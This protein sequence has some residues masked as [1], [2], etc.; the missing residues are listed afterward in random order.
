MIFESYSTEGD[1]VYNYH[2]KYYNNSMLEFDHFDSG[3]KVPCELQTVGTTA[4]DHMSHCKTEEKSSLDNLKKRKINETDN[5]HECKKYRN[6]I[7]AAKYRKKRNSEINE[8]IKQ[9]KSEQ[10]EL[11]KRPKDNMYIKFLRK[12][13]QRIPKDDKKERNR[14]SAMIYRERKRMFLQELACL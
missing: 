9:I 10:K 3:D 8:L 5:Y 1:F 13:A 14:Y 11:P 7:A 4:L 12:E 6:K 2:Q